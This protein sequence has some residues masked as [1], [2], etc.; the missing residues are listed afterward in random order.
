MIENK[1]LVS[2]LN[3]SD[4]SQTRRALVQ[5]P[6]FLPQATSVPALNVDRW[7]SQPS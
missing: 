4:F 5:T 1:A 2:H 6:T 7:N 3:L